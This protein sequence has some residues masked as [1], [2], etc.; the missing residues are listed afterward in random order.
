MHIRVNMRFN[1]TTMLD[2]PIYDWLRKIKKTER[3]RAIKQRLADSFTPQEIRSTRK[4][5]TKSSPVLHVE[6]PTE[7]PLTIEPPPPLQEPKVPSFAGFRR[8]TR[9]TSP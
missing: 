1:N 8:L 3:S 7:D 4:P 6:H 2:K 9:P 5:K